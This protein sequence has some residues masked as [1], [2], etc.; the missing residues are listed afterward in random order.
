M[1][2]LT[3]SGIGIFT[4]IGKNIEEHKL[5]LSNGSSGARLISNFNTEKFNKKYA[6][7]IGMKKSLIKYPNLHL[8]DVIEQCLSDAKRKI[9]LD[10][11][12][13]IGTGLRNFRGYEIWRES[14]LQFQYNFENLFFDKKAFVENFGIPKDIM[15]ISNACASSLYIISIA[16]SLIRNNQCSK[17][18]IASYDYINKTMY[19]LVDKVNPNHPIEIMP[20]DKD[21]PG[22]LMGDG[23][24]AILIEKKTIYSQKK[25]SI[26]SISVSC[27]GSHET[28]P[29]KE[30]IKRTIEDAIKLANIEPE[31][32][33]LIISHG[34]GTIHNDDAEGWAIS[35]IFKTPPHPFLTANKS[36]I[37]HTSGS[38][39]LIGL[40]I[41]IIS[42]ENNIY[43]PITTLKN[44]IEHVKPFMKNN[45]KRKMKY[46]IV[47]AFGFGGVNAVTVVKYDN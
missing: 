33:D 39:G 23:S 17:V 1:E 15:V 12:V 25:F 16:E 43:F 38:S 26:E 40:I 24:A 36:Q 10:T 8:F 27:D 5:C 47:N 32:V 35:E 6:Y 28:I 14:N 30:N 45:T 22:V 41:A 44:P 46:A 4:S 42:L 31:Q 9:D 13:L 3:I 37:G 34:T 18:L 19:G 21:R 11:I 2:R 7:E 29:D 20:F